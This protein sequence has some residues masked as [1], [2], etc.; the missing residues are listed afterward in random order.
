MLIR[1]IALA[2]FATI[3]TAPATAQDVPNANK[4]VRSNSSTT[5]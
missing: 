3:A 1:T 2:L 5:L 4:A